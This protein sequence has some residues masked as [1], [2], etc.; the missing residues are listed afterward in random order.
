MTGASFYNS[1]TGFNQVT[2]YAASGQ[3]TASL[4][5]SSGQDQYVSGAARVTLRG[6]SFEN[7]AVGFAEVN[8]FGA[9]GQ[10]IANF[11]SAAANVDRDFFQALGQAQSSS[12]F[13]SPAALTQVHMAELLVGFEFATART[14][15][16]AKLEVAALDALFG[17]EGQW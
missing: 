13:A 10:S 7:T 8:S 15:Q 2:A 6:A 9:Q 12:E 14:A 5:E 16:Q 3:D 1:A 11:N 4:Y 17:E